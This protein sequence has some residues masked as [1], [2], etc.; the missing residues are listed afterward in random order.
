MNFITI[1]RIFFSCLVDGL[2]TCRVM[3][4]FGCGLVVWVRDELGEG[5]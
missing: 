3:G 5:M 2:T 4:G 1:A